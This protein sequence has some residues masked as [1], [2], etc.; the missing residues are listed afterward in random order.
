MGVRLNKAVA[1]IINVVAAVSAAFL[2]VFVERIGP[3][4]ASFGNL[5]G[6]SGNENC[7]KPVLNGGFPFSYL[8]DMPGVSVENQL[9]FA[10]DI[11]RLNPFLSDIAFYFMVLLCLVFA[12]KCVSRSRCF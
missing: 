10:E 4:V 9:S 8:F 6:P 2:S 12:K 7:P 5:C 3:E 1:I 11:F